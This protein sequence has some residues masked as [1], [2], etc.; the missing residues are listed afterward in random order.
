[1]PCRATWGLLLGT[2][3]IT[4]LGGRQAGFVVSRGWGAPWFPREAMAG[5]SE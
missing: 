3:R 2:G 4:R 5:L 1:M